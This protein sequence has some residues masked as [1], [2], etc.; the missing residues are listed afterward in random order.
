MAVIFYYR[1]RVT[2][3][4]VACVQQLAEQP[5]P[6]ACQAARSEARCCTEVV[7]KWSGIVRGFIRSGVYTVY[8]YPQ[9]VAGQK[10]RRPRSQFTAAS[11][12]SFQS[13]VLT[14]DDVHGRR[15]GRQVVNCGLRTRG[16]MYR[17]G[18]IR[19]LCCSG[20]RSMASE[21]KVNL[22][23]E[24]VRRAHPSLPALAK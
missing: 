6:L 2:A 15:R 3:A 20:E 1:L 9:V 13:R 5:I 4:P 10:V 18:A 8:A 16:S 14:S 7:S 12:S 11:T 23:R 17:S 21:R 19:R 24:S 22:R